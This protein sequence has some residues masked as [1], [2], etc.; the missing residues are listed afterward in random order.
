M[1][2]DSK[3]PASASPARASVPAASA[4]TAAASTPQLSGRRQS[5]WTIAALAAGSS[6]GQQAVM[7]LADGP[8]QRWTLLLAA[9]RELPH[10]QMRPFSSAMDVVRRVTAEQGIRAWWR[11]AGFEAVGRMIGL[12]PV[13]L[14]PHFVKPYEPRTHAHAHSPPR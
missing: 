6:L 12:G 7:S 5:P 9:Q 14:L 3:A 10:A 11:G 13:I 1:S 8:F 2:G 4:A